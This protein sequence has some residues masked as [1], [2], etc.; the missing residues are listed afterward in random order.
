MRKLSTTRLNKSQQDA[1]DA[2]R[3]DTG[4]GRIHGATITSWHGT[5]EIDL[6]ALFARAPLGATVAGGACDEPARY[7]SSTVALSDGTRITFAESGQ[8][9]DASTI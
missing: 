4:P 7:V 1:L 8:F 5:P 9:I 2:E 6:D 3:A